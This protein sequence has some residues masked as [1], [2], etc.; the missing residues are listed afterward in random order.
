MVP[1]PARQHNTP[2][3]VLSNNSIFFFNRLPMGL[4]INEKEAQSAVQQK[5]PR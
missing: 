5:L 4:R 1:Q 2:T 3:R